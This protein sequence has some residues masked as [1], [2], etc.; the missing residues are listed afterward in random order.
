MTSRADEIHK[1]IADIDNLLSNS[2]NRLSKLLSGQGQEDKDVLQ[3]VRDFLVKLDESEESAESS[4]PKESETP[5]LSSLLTRFVEQEQ[6]QSASHSYQSQQ[7]QS[8]LTAG[9]FKDEISFLLQPLQAELSGLLEERA[10]LVK[11]IRQLEQKR[12]Q[13]YS[14]TQQLANQEQIISEFLQV[15]ISRLVPNLLPYLTKTLPTS[16]GLSTSEQKQEAL[17]SA[18]Q[19]V[20][21]SVEETDRLATLARELDQRLLSLDGTVNVVFS[22]LERNITTY[23]Q[24]LSQALAK[25]HSQGIQGEQLMA[26]F[27]NNLTQHL[28]QQSP[29]AQSFLFGVDT[30][31]VSSPTSYNAEE[32]IQDIAAETEESPAVE[33]LDRVLSELTADESLASVTETLNIP[34]ELQPEDAVEEELI[35]DIA[36]ETEESPAVEN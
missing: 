13:N 16:P 28:Q 35:Q 7:E 22:S 8:N 27:L 36:A 9:Q 18:V 12:L 33:N 6:N 19:P 3:R 5:P 24:S 20:L 34:D 10:A 23:H 1:L 14:L 26:N 32:L 25:M 15:L 21:G 29:D 31:T 4:V 17:N 11:E 30:Q 2:G